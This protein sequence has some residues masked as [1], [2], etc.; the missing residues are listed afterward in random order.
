VRTSACFALFLILAACDAPK[1]AIPALT[2]EGAMQL[3][4]NSGRAQDWLTVVKKRDPSCDY[5]LDL[6]DQLSHP[7]EIDLSHIVSCGGRPSPMEL[8]ASVSFEYDPAAQH[9]VIKRFAS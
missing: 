7:T 3:L 6:G 2:P 8:D 9:W 1:P 4:H 5:K